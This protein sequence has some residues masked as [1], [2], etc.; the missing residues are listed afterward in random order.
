M[1]LELLDNQVIGLD[2]ALRFNLFYI[3]SGVFV[4]ASSSVLIFQVG[5]KD[6]CLLNLSF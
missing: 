4:S 3:H 6:I 5:T 1:T 2:K